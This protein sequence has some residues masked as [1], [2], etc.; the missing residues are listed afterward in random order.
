LPAESTL[1]YDQHNVIYA[2]GPLNRF[3]EVLRKQG[4]K[5]G[6]VRFPSPHAHN[7]NPE[8]DEEETRVLE[9]CEWLPTPL[10][11]DDDL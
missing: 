7:Y 8:N 3:E 1:V 2:Y 4:F 9:Y 5:T 10:M 11:K 6:A